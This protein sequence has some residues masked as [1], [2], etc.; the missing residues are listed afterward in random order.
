M[1]SVNISDDTVVETRLRHSG[2]RRNW[3]S[4]GA[5]PSARL[6]AIASLIRSKK[7]PHENAK[8]SSSLDTRQ[9]TEAVEEKYKRVLEIPKIDLTDA[10]EI[11]SYVTIQEWEGYVNEVDGDIVRASL[12][13]ITAGARDVTELAEIPIDEFSSEDRGRL[14]R[15]AVFRWALGLQRRG[16]TQ[17]RSSQIVVRHLPAWKRSELVEADVLG[18]KL[19]AKLLSGAEKDDTTGPRRD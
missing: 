19:S 15:G 14:F 6:T 10:S 8:D 7:I 3:T 2:N 5:N 17:T 16:S 1:R 12:S 11:V 4:V 9:H 13:D 18:R